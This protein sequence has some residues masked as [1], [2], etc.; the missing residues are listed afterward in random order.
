MRPYT[1]LVL[2]LAVTAAGCTRG[3][4][5]LSAS[6]SGYNLILINI[7]S[8]RADHLSFYGY[9]RAT[10]PF[11]DALAEESVVYDDA[12]AN[13]SYTRTS[14]ASL[15]TGKLP[16]SAGIAGWDSKPPSDTPTLAQRLRAR[17]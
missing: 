10:S 6:L 7:D 5:D 12:F 15:F 14:V 13:S 9:D 2:C 11:L 8:L 17:G 1:L 4:S 3:R 16:S